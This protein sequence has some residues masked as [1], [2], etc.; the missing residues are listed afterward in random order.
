M[1]SAPAREKAMT[2]RIEATPI[3]LDVESPDTGDGPQRIQ[4]LPPL[5]KPDLQTMRGES[6]TGCI[7]VSVII[8]QLI[9]DGWASAPFPEDS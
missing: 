7:V 4:D 5:P 9:A 8:D 2:A 1:I 3:A 6:T